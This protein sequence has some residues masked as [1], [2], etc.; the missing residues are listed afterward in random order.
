MEHSGEKAKKLCNLAS[1]FI[2]AQ[3]YPVLKE[4]DLFLLIKKVQGE[5]FTRLRDL[6]LI[7]L[8]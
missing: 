3:C 8:H 4:K 5:T 1:I 7:D 2:M 6:S